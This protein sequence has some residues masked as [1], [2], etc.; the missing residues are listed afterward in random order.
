MGAGAAECGG[1]EEAGALARRQRRRLRRLVALVAPEGIR[2]QASAEPRRAEEVGAAG[3]SEGLAGQREA[4][5]EQR[6]GPVA[7]PRLRAS[8]GAAAGKA[9]AVRA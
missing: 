3:E 8:G 6:G 9:E 7:R 5:P 4:E 2:T 1:A